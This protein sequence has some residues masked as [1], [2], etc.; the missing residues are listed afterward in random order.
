MSQIVVLNRE[1]QYWMEADLK[2]ILKLWVKNKIEI[3][4]VDESREI[5]SSDPTNEYLIKIKMPLVVRLLS[6]FKVPT[7]KSGHIA[8]TDKAVYDRDNNICQY[9]HEENG[10]RF[11]YKCTAEERTIDHVIPKSRGGDNSFTNKVC[12][13]RWHNEVVK[14]NHTPKEAGL[15]L[16]RQPFVPIRNKGDAIFIRFTFD[17]NKRAHKALLEYFGVEFT[18]VA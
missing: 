5:S 11:K 9:W 1:Y 12:C 10:K 4:K 17:P 3:L 7:Y 15:V 2:R 13:C 16:V 6:K 8:N 14:K 18:H